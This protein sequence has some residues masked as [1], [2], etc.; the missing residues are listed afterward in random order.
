MSVEQTEDNYISLSAVY[1]FA[2]TAQNVLFL[3]W[4]NDTLII[5]VIYTSHMSK[6]DTSYICKKAK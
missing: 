6:Y 5:Y 2:D 3:H 1:T 4:C